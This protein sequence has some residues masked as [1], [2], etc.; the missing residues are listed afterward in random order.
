MKIWM[1]YAILAVLGLPVALLN[2][3]IG[4][5]WTLGHVVMIL[6]VFSRERFYGILLDTSKF[7]VSKYISYI[8]FTIA[9]LAVPLGLSFLFQ[10][11]LN[12]FA[13][14]TAYF[15]DRA[16]HFIFNLFMKEETHAS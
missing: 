1:I 8:V 6:L 13:L 9:L 12:P 3:S 16:V 15:T 10:D 2:S 7:S 5:A 14:F 4:L 11:I